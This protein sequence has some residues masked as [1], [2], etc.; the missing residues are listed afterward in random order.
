MH[1]REGRDDARVVQVLVV[2]SD[3][4]REQH[5]LVDDRARRHR[6][7]VELLAVLEVQRLDRMAGALAN[8]VELAL[9]RVGDGDA[10]AATDEHLPDHG[11]ELLRGLGQ[12]GVVDGHVTPAEQHLALVLDRPFDLVLAREPA[13]GLLRQEDHP[14]TVLARGREGHALLRH[15][16][17][18]E[19][20]RH[21]DEDAG[22]VAQLRV[23]TDR[24][25]VNEVLE[26]LKT[27]VDDRMAFL[28]LDVRDE[29]D[30]ARVVLVLGV[31][32]ALRLR[33]RG[34]VHGTPRN[35]CTRA[36][37]QTTAVRPFLHAEP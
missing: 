29:A 9:Q 24:T 30:A 15:L 27:L 26:D 7:H 8:D 18:E 19:L 34:V 37:G 17:A 4:L 28:P 32:E 1:E 12:V 36:K 20:V 10:R 31:V 13:R 35:T 21:L 16:L 22:P 25:P 3:L 14:D 5:A 23:E 2:R 6:R 33:E 11:L